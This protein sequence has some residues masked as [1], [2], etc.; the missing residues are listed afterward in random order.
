MHTAYYVN[1]FEYL[2][3][4]EERWG[5][6]GETP[7][8]DV[9]SSDESLSDLRESCRLL[10]LT[11]EFAIN[12]HEN[13]ISYIVGSG[14]TITVEAKPGCSVSPDVLQQAQRWLDDFAERNR[15]F[16]RQQE[17]IRRKDRDGEAFLRLFTGDDG[18]T[19]VRFV[20]PEQVRTPRELESS[21]DDTLVSNRLGIQTL[22]RDVEQ[23]RGYWV[24]GF[25]V[26][27][28]E[29]QHRKANVDSNVLRGIPTFFPVR[30]NLRRAEK[31][32][33]NMST[34][35]EIQSAIAII[36]KHHTGSKF[37]VESFASSAAD[38]R[39]N[40]GNRELFYRQYSPG[41]ILDTS[42][43]V[44]YQFPAATIDASRYVTILQA[45]LRAIASR[46]VMPEFMLTSDASNANYS[47]TMIAEGPAVR[48]FERL[49]HEMVHEDTRLLQ[50]VLRNGVYAGQLPAEIQTSVRVR[51][52]PPALA[53][54]DR[55]AEIEADRILV[56]LG[57][58]SV[59]ELASKYGCQE[60]APRV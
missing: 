59:Q 17:I 22:R 8:S 56:E 16:E 45:E 47:S 18:Q 35:A 33:R 26:P 20:E 2:F 50:Q 5:F 3:D 1:P 41:T 52:T 51:V 49:Q 29:I 38:C 19:L 43:N 54:H 23:I 15:W 53:V 42:G 36:R 40:S 13:R 48:M 39:V 21:Q 28:L 60:N 14:H 57:A 55:K 9:M 25:F 37:G 10:A 4:D 58:M 27:A 34:V 32:L 11:N 44:D 30:K 12:A 24:D 6:T 46:L 7:I 31:L